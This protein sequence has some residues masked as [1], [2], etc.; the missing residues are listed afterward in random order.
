MYSDL[1]R[2]L[3]TMLEELGSEPDPE[4]KDIGMEEIENEIKVAEEDLAKE[5]QKIEQIKLKSLQEAMNDEV[6]YI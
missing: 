6:V 3:D 4:F 5:Y 1:T 2:A